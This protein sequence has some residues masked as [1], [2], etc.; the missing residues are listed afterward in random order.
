[1]RHTKQTRALSRGKQL[2]RSE[3]LEE[4]GSDIRYLPPFFVAALM[5]FNLN[6]SDVV[7]LSHTMVRRQVTLC[8]TAAD[9]RTIPSDYVTAGLRRVAML[10]M[11]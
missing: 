9:C 2:T 5:F 11:M 7:L 10:E 3:G 4:N 1:M 6:C 8:Q